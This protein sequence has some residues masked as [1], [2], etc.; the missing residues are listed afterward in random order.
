[1]VVHRHAEVHHGIDAVLGTGAGVRG[2][3]HYPETDE[4]PDRGI[5]VV[6]VGLD[7]ENR[8]LLPV[9]AGEHPLPLFH[10]HL[11][12]QVP[13]RTRPGLLLCLA[14]ILDRAGADIS[15]ALLDELSGQ[16]VIELESIALDNGLVHLDPH[17]LQVLGDHII[18]VRVDLVRVG[19]LHPV[20]ELAIVT[21]A[22]LVVE[23]GHPGVPEVQRTRRP[24]SE[25]H[26]HLPLHRVRQVGQLVHPSPPS[27]SSP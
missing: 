13:V 24:G 15:L 10:L 5:G 9:V 12:R 16:V 22:V 26:D 20:D 6:Q 19:V 4:V 1:M 25:T 23:D 3:G 14:P 8:L 2:A 27:P 17:P 7:H 18:G 11:L 21:L